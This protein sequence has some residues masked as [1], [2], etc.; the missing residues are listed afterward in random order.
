M[1]DDVGV[2]EAFRES[3]CVFMLRWLTPPLSKPVDEFCHFDCSSKHRQLQQDPARATS[4]SNSSPPQVLAVHF[5]HG[6]PSHSV[7]DLSVSMLRKIDEITRVDLELYAHGVLRFV[8]E[9]EVVERRY[10][11]TILCPA[12]RS[13]LMRNLPQIPVSHVDTVPGR[14]T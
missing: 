9:V 3:V 12:R 10:N 2:V 11:R 8:R 7:K 1:F 6:V 5:A 4:P 13:T 14:G